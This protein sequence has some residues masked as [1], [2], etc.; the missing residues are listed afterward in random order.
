MKA[1]SS[2]SNAATRYDPR[3]GDTVQRTPPPKPQ[4]QVYSPSPDAP[5]RLAPSDD[6]VTAPNVPNAPDAPN[7]ANRSK[8]SA[9]PPP[10]EASQLLNHVGIRTTADENTIISQ[11]ILANSKQSF[12]GYAPDV[13]EFHE[14][15]NAIFEG[16][17]RLSPPRR[18]FYEGEAATLSGAFSNES[19]LGR[20]NAL[21]GM[22]D[23]LLD[24]VTNEAAT[25]GTTDEGIVSAVFNAPPGVGL[26]AKGGQAERQKLSGLW[27]TFRA[28]DL[29]T[30]HRAVSD[31]IAHNAG[32][33]EQIN[34]VVDAQT[35]TQNSDWKQAFDNA[36]NIL[37]E[38]VTIKDPG[39][40]Y[41]SIGRKL[42]ANRMSD[43]P[44]RS[45]ELLA[46]T[47]R[48]KSPEVAE[49]LDKWHVDAAGPLNAEGVGAP[50]RYTDILKNLPEPNDSYVEN[51]AK[52]YNEVFHDATEKDIS[53]TPAARRNA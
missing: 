28:G 11:K 37:Q 39:M 51:L 10:S 31:A 2:N 8:R 3:P 52:R 23:Q 53:I 21:T 1:T 13:Q 35:G 42:F 49:K 15:L 45:R 12:T 9:E 16:T 6:P 18:D 46:F 44:Q 7:A 36:D 30:R 17:Q 38:A 33:R 22:Q 41:E 4:P 25:F 14:R 24:H 43:N 32:L 26:L 29:E 5:E 48:M 50:P 40:R 27:Q 20:R 34:P 19:D 47:E